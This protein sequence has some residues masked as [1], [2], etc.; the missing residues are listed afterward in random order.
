MDVFAIPVSDLRNGPVERAVRIEDPKAAFGELPVDM[1]PL[2][3]TV[4][5][6]RDG[7]GGVRAKGTLH[8]DVSLEC[9]RCLKDLSVSIDATLDALFRPA[10]TVGPDEEGIW[11]LSEDD[12]VADLTPALREELWVSVPEYVECETECEGLCPR[13][14]V[15][16]GE[17]ICE[18][19]PPG[20]DPRWAALDA[21]RD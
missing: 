13:C 4:T 11:A 5:A 12:A 3:I 1:G 9:R 16:L 8:A 19:P 10:T 15:R 7:G 21:L 17:E 6:D 18:C 14:G 2:D 20:P